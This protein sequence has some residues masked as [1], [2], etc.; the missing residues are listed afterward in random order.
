MDFELSDLLLGHAIALIG[1]GIVTPLVLNAV[2]KWQGITANPEP[3]K[4]APRPVPGWLTGLLERLLFT[5]LVALS[6]S[7]TAVAMIAWLGIKLAAD[8]SR[9]DGEM[10]VAIWRGMA[11]SAL[12]AGMVSMLFALA[13]GILCRG[14]LDV[15][16]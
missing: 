15:T 5:W 8:W 12:L 14:T 4:G 11:A 13:G 7:G 3:P 6:V 9:P 2:R 10:N 16:F 1:G